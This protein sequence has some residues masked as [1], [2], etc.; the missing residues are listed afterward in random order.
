MSG[1][2]FWTWRMPGRSLL[3]EVTSPQLVIRTLERTIGYVIV[4]GYETFAYWVVIKL[5]QAIPA[6]DS[7]RSVEAQDSSYFE[8]VKS[9]L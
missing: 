4:P 6:R 9:M 3:Y 1:V 5:G 8:I 7:V 2:Y